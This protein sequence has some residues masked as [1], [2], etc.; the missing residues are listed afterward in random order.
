MVIFWWGTW[1]LLERYL[2][3]NHQA[4]NYIVGI[5]IGLSLL[6]WNDRSFKEMA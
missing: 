6:Y 4:V 5:V 2:L 1:G 3:P